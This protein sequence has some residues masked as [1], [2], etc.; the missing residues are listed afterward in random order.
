MNVNPS[1]C[2]DDYIFFNYGNN[3]SYMDGNPQRKYEY[4]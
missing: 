2:A 3:N 1:K 4:I